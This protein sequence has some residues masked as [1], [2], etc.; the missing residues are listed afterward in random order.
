M[1]VFLILGNLKLCDLLV[2]LV[3][4]R[5]GCGLLIGS[6]YVG[7]WLRVLS[8]E[9]QQ[10]TYSKELTARVPNAL[11]FLAVRGVFPLSLPGVLKT[12]VTLLCDV[13]TGLFWTWMQRT[14]DLR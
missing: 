10:S 11:R 3:L 2:E 13:S 6:K 7:Q 4:R 14:V 5:T 9:M 12:S 1:T 8:V